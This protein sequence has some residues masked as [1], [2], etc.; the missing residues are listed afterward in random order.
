MWNVSSQKLPRPPGPFHDFLV[1][2]LNC[3]YTSVSGLVTMQLDVPLELYA[4]DQNLSFRSNVYAWIYDKIRTNRLHCLH[5]VLS[6]IVL[7]MFR[8][9]LLLTIRR[10][11]CVYTAV[12]VCHAF[13]FTGWW[14]DPSQSCQKPSSGSLPSTTCFSTWTRPHIVTLLS[15]GSGYFRAKRFPLKIPQH[16]QPQL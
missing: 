12:G 15:I 11:Y 3:N 9:G 4:C 7:Y 1:P 8:T 13:M 2:W 14:Q 6:I 10:F 5:S 16:S